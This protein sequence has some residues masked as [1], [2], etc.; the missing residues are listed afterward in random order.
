MSAIVVL[1]LLLAGLS[2]AVGRILPL[3]ARRPTVARAPVVGM[4]FTGAFVD[5]SVIALWPVTSGVL[6]GTLFASS[7]I[8]AVAGWTPTLLAPLLFSAVLAFP[9]LG[10]F[11]HFALFVGVGAGL[12][13]ALAGAQ[14]IDWWAAA[15]CVGVAGVVL[16]LTVEGVRRLVVAVTLRRAPVVTM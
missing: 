9:L 3:V 16:A 8:G 6:A 13:G 5:G 14:G 7:G 4:L 12:S 10:P 11:L 15:G 1:L 2:E